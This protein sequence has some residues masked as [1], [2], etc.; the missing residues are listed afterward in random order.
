MP[1]ELKK[2]D[3]TEVLL[4][5]EK[6]YYPSKE[7]LARASIKNY[8]EIAVKAQEDPESFWEEAA[9]ELE[10]YKKWN[11]VLDDSKKPF[12]QWFSG[13]KCNIFHNALERHQ[14]TEVKD[15]VAYYWEDESGN[16][17][18]ITYAELYQMT[19]QFAGILKKLGIQKGDRVSI[20]M[21]NIP[22]TAMALLA[23][24]KLGAIHSVVYAG[25]SAQALADRINDA[26]AKVLITVDGGKRR[27]KPIKLK[28]TADSALE[29][30]P[31]VKYVVVIK[32][33]N[34]PVTM[35]QGRDFLYDDLKKEKVEIPRTEEM[36]STDPLF[37]LYT[38][39]T[40]AKPKGVIHV[41]GGYQ[42]GISRTLKWV[43]DL[44]DNDIYWSTADP[45]WITGHSYIVYAPLICGAT[46]VMYDGAPDYP[47]ADRL[48]QVVEKYKVT[49]FYTAPTVIRMMMK[50]GTAWPKK[51]KMA[52]LRL[53]G[54]VGE[55][56]NPE[57]WRW[58]YENIGKKL[59][60]VM[61]TWW[62][63]ETG[64]FMLCPLPVLPLK[65]GSVVKPFPGIEA[66]VVDQGG[67]TVPVGK[68]G[69]L[70]I[71]T[72]WPAMLSNLYK[73]P[74]R[75]LETYFEK[76][77]GV[78]TTGDLATKDK[79][80]YFWIQGR[81]DDV[82]KIAGHR[83]GN[84]EI[85]SALVAH[86]S[87]AEAGVIGIPDEIRGEIAK[88]FVI[89]KKGIEPE[90]ELK[91][92]LKLKVRE[93]LGPVVIFKDIQYVDKLP[94]TRSGKIMRRVLKAQELGLP[95]G[96]TSTLEE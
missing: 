67:K 23:C 25:F 22:E 40:T 8:E 20:Y 57:A 74:K 52:S 88:A 26:E 76:I 96:D 13:A 41:H 64:M 89:L 61:N 17:R 77:P 19:N 49:I 38:S 4:K 46:S 12:Y 27:N 28:E 75:Y 54:T 37:I 16:N 3:L 80:G 15:K 47:E 95:L 51:Y 62:Q 65:A 56:I 93:T 48:W 42:V 71:K 94:K 18:K 32:Y 21:P 92:E 83:I 84:A 66:E 55:P 79:D 50:Y 7:V 35:K 6:F 72:P 85:E 2:D 70:V 1:D 36:E 31:T 91:E 86:P 58:Y 53:L 10:W 87:V 81:S 11:K 82:L 78:Y 33:A 43:F 90:E 9:N 63:T 44:K 69:F 24:A 34:I 59:C 73:N 29:N 60:P 45:G 39:G 5:E 68:G 30:C 14:K